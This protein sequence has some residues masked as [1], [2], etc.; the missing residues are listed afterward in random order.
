MN[1]ES[2]F[3]KEFDA[4]LKN[5]KN[6]GKTAKSINV[7][8]HGSSINLHPLVIKL[9]NGEKTVLKKDYGFDETFDIFEELDDKRS[10]LNEYKRRT[11][12]KINIK[13]AMLEYLRI[14]KDKL[15]D[16]FTTPS[17]KNKNA[18]NTN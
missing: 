1:S 5:I 4:M 15:I 3:T 14:M 18:N 10:K 7:K 9:I 13:N 2:N 6:N 12:I 8:N 11:S 16:M 17:I